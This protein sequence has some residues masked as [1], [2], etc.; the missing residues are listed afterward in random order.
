MILICGDIEKYFLKIN[1]DIILCIEVLEH[2]NNPKETLAKFNKMLKKG[3]KLYLQI[4]VCNL[5][6]PKFFIYL[7]RTIK[8]IDHDMADSVHV[9]SFSTNDIIKILED[10]NYRINEIRHHSILRE[11]N[12]NDFHLMEKK[13]AA[14]CIIIAEKIV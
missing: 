14:R 3:G 9:S 8:G 12:L 13:L 11:F 6:F 4:P 10:A 1:A 2:L 7:F 5:P